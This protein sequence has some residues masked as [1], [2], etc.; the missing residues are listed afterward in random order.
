MLVIGGRSIAYVDLDEVRLDG[1]ASQIAAFGGGRHEISFL[2]E[3]HDEFVETFVAAR[4]RSRARRLL[5]WTGDEPI[6]EY[7]SRAGDEPL[8]VVLFPDG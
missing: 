8:T 5:Q 7:G 3:Q 6:D 4:R 1:H 2:G